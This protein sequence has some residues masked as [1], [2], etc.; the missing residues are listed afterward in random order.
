M[1]DLVGGV[2]NANPGRE[3]KSLKGYPLSFIQWRRPLKQKQKQKQNLTV[4]ICSVEELEDDDLVE[5]NEGVSTSEGRSILPSE[6][7]LALSSR[8]KLT[9]V[10]K[11]AALFSEVS[12]LSFVGI[13]SKIVE[14]RTEGEG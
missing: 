5:E 4:N 11:R 10:N 6:G 12:R 14:V 1:F 13:Q 2:T 8:E 9:S 7:I 3:A